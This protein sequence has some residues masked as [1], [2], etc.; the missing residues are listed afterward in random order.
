MRVREL[1]V[2]R[3]GALQDFGMGG[4]DAPLGS[5]VVLVGPNEGGKSTL[6]TLITTLLYGFTPATRENHPYAPWGGEENLEAWARLARDREPGEVWEVRRRLLSRP[7][8]YLRGPSGREDLANRPL[9]WVPSAVPE[10]VYR[11]VFALTLPEMAALGDEGWEAVQD[12]LL[13]GMGVRD[14]R[15][16]RAVIQELEAEFGSLWRP[17]RRGHQEIRALDRDLR[18]ARRRRRDLEERDRELR[19]RTEELARTREELARLRREREALL[20]RLERIQELR[21]L[22]LQLLRI[23]ELE[24]TATDPGALEE[25]PP[26]PEARLVELE[27]QRLEGA[28]RREELEERAIR[29]RE[30]CRALS[31]EVEELLA[32]EATILSL[33]ERAA[34]QSARLPLMGS[35]EQEIRDLERRCENRARE[36][37]HGPWDDLPRDPLRQLSLREVGEAVRGIR[38][39]RDARRIH[40]EARSLAQQQR[41][42]LPPVDLWSGVALLA[43]GAVLLL[44]GLLQ[45]EALLLV[46]GPVTIILGGALLLARKRARPDDQ[47]EEGESDPGPTEEEKGRHALARVL[48]ELP[49][50][51]GILQDPPVDLA[52]RLGSLQQYLQDLGERRER[53]QELA[54]EREDLERGLAELAHNHGLTPGADPGTTALRLRETLDEARAIREKALAARE[55]LDTV[56]EDV[57]SLARELV[58]TREE[59]R[60]LRKRLEHLGHGSLE[61]GLHRVT[62]ERTALEEARL[63]H[64][65]LERRHPDLEERIA[66]IREAEREGASWTRDEEAMVRDRARDKELE[67]RIQELYREEGT[68]AGEVRRLEAMESSADAGGEILALQEARARAA[69]KR[70]RLYLLSRILLEADRRIREEHQPGVLKRAGQYLDRITG[71]RYR[72]ILPGDD[73]L[74]YLRD[75]GTGREIAVREPLSQGTREQVYL[76]LRLSVLDQLDQGGERLPLCVDEALVNWDRLRL[77]RGL[78]LLEEVSRTR[79]IFVFTCQPHIA[80][81]LGRRGGQLFQ[82]QEPSS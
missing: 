47:E 48:G 64:R 34:S 42:A 30:R 70:D 28:T 53:L 49:V 23:R 9:P 82:L 10:K 66:R 40:R 15:P 43:L 73:D 56:E 51:E 7:D 57:E 72:L 38:E 78:D 76:A 17:N 62:R 55:E 14:L 21:P 46:L 68:L 11:Q 52:E 75:P 33:S 12:R 13:A 69:R 8:G 39:A 22:R 4:Q 19:L 74:F 6:F 31:P 60:E 44:L 63:L 5:L 24:E 61:A 79:Q 26:D 77:E 37:F 80:E 27:E 3:F 59:D 58:E 54:R 1:Q 41:A 35:L 65:E 18:E 67:A 20:L 45:T 2:R 16:P 32:S 25:L 71:G 50:R 29:L 81:A 36:I